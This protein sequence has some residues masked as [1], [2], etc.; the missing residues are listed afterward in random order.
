MN[1]RLLDGEMFWIVEEAT[2]AWIIRSESKQAKHLV[3]RPRSPC[4]SKGN[5]K[6]QLVF[7]H[8]E[9]PRLAQTAAHVVLTS[10]AA[11]RGIISP[12]FF[13]R[14]QAAVV[15]TFASYRLL[16]SDNKIIK[17]SKMHG[18]SSNLFCFET[19]LSKYAYGSL[20]W[21]KWVI[22]PSNHPHEYTLYTDYMSPRNELHLWS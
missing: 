17:K 4:V 11:D 5:D 9:S 8:S 14:A 6:F 22:S 20:M 3:M 7:A 19:L 16:Y 18:G 1:A 13:V 12:G 10:S 15:P 2:G 21:V